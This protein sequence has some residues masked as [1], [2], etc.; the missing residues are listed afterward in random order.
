[1]SYIDTRSLIEE[2]EEL[3]QTVL[4][5]YN[6]EFEAD[7]S[8]FDEITVAL[9]GDDLGEVDYT[10]EEIDRLN[11]FKD[12]YSDELEQIEQINDLENEVG[13]EWEYGVTLIEGDDFEEYCKELVE[14]CGYISKDFPSW[15]EVDWSETANNMRVD[16][17]EVEFRGTNYLFR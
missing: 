16:Y 7:F 6:E 5:A 12:L 17:S 3:Q 11:D 9:L 14:D 13:S 1:M 10:E 15:I 8:D 4:D 2:R